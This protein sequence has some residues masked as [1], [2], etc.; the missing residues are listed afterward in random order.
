MTGPVHTSGFSPR[1]GKTCDDEKPFAVPVRRYREMSQKSMRA[2]STA[3]TVK[4]R[5]RSL[6]K[7]W[8]EPHARE[9][10][11]GGCLPVP[12]CGIVLTVISVVGDW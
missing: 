12:R 11:W 9:S 8:A 6:P 7:A 1:Q 4:Q 10:A 2:P 5:P 3:S